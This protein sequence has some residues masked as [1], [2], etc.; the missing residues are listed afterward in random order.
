MRHSASFAIDNPAAWKLRLLVW[1]D[2]HN[3]AVYLDSND[4]PAGRYGYWDC[5]VAADACE[6]LECAAGHAF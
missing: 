4:Y 6:T 2:Q 5:L 1:A 3:P